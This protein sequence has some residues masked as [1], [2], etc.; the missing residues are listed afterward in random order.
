MYYVDYHLHSKY[1]FDAEEEMDAVCDAAIATGIS[2]IAITDH[3]DLYK[4][5][6]YSYMLNT[7]KWYPDLMRIKEKYKGKLVVRAGI[8]LGSPQTAPVESA[9]FLGRYPLDFVIG[10]IH[11]LENDKDAAD[12]NY[13]KTD[14]KDFYPHY[15]DWLIELAKDYD[16]DVLGHLSYPSRYINLQIHE[17]PDLHI[18]EEQF[19]ILFAILKERGKG[20]ELNTSGYARGQNF[21]MPPIWLVKMYRE[22]GGEIITT[23]SDAHVASQVGSTVK[24]AYDFLKEAGF[25]YFTTYKER[26]PEFH[27]L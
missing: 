20:I 7:Q 19:R 12:Y 6:P 4:D 10:S 24:L 11:N 25:Y 3:L 23:G 14:Y 21:T 13:M 8:E 27:K 16:Y 15:I 17:M 26:K 22:C 5:K 9:A 2:E 1:S 18:Y